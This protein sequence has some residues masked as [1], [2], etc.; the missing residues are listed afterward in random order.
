MSS[1]SR[2]HQRCPFC[3]ELQEVTAWQS[4]NV[5]LN[6]VVKPQLLDGSLFAFLDLR[7]KKR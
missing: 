1:L 7:A 6:P 2:V 4:L 5:T 3:S